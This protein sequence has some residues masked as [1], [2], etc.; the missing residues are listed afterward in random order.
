M[1]HADDEAGVAE[2]EHMGDVGLTPTLKFMR[3]EVAPR[4]PCPIIPDRA[5]WAAAAIRKTLEVDNH[6]RSA[7]I[8]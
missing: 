4:K 5:H 6:P 7:R 3:H 2:A 8:A 1:P